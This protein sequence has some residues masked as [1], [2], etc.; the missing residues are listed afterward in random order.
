MEGTLFP[1]LTVMGFQE[2]V[3]ASTLVPQTLLRLSAVAVCPELL[4]ILHHGH[5]ELVRMVTVCKGMEGKLQT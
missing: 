5:P 2:W 3:G 1:L 4:N